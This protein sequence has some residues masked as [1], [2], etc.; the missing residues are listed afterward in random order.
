MYI[1]HNLNTLL[2]QLGKF[3]LVIRDDKSCIMQTP[4]IYHI[5]PLE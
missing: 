4:P 1:K 2:D 3:E 5:F